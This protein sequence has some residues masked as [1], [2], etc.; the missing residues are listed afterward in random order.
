MIISFSVNL[1]RCD[2]NLKLIS[3][4]KTIFNIYLDFVY[5]MYWESTLFS[6]QDCPLLLICHSANIVALFQLAESKQSQ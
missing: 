2:V 1:L 3:N 4:F 6:A 5:M